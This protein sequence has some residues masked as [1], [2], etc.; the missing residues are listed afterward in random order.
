MKKH[1]ASHEINIYSSAPKR[2]PFPQH[3]VFYNGTQEEPDRLTLRLSDLF[4][5][6]HTDCTPCLECLTTMLNINYGH[7][8]ALMEKCL[9]LKEYAIFVDTVR[10]ISLLIFP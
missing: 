8:R 10:N 3:I 7:N 6:P 4:E 1:I 9:R 2:L 5:R